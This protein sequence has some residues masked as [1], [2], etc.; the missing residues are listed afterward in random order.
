[1]ATKEQK[2]K[3]ISSSKKLS[4][5]SGA[6]GRLS[7]NFGSDRAEV[8]VGKIKFPVHRL[9]KKG[10]VGIGLAAAASIGAT[11]Q[12]FRGSSGVG[13]FLGR[14]FITNPLRVI[15]ANLATAGAV[16]SL[17]RAAK[18]ATTPKIV[19]SNGR[20][21]KDVTPGG[22]IFRRIRGRIVPVRKK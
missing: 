18:A 12:N 16:G 6:L 5:L 21:M 19:N 2:E 14:E 1:M 7:H 4:Y 15:G 3:R 11:V 22:I 9:N 20:K 17:R 13:E 10:R 8:L